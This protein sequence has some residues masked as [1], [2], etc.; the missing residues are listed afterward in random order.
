MSI[1]NEH[2]KTLVLATRNLHKADEIR[3]I[4]SGL[5]QCRTLNDFP[6]AP[7]VVEDA[8][9]F[10]GN[11]NKKAVQLAQWMARTRK[12][13][14]AN[15]NVYVLADDSGLEVDALQGAPGVYSAR[16]AALDQSDDGSGMEGNSTDDANNAKLLC[17]LEHVPL[18]KRTARFRCV[19]ALAEAALDPHPLIFEGV[20]E[21][22]IDFTPRG[23]GG[24]G[25]DPLFVPIEQDQ[26]FTDLGERGKTKR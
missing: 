2:S 21:G 9:T 7:A 14:S 3:A 22:R 8:A 26:S 24:F 25:S 17:L 1:P 6:D 23:L 12:A 19:L 11:A 16:F 13:E 4:L 5:C 15:R 18:E 20:C 10:V